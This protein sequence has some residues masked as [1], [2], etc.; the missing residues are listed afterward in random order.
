MRSTLLA[1][2]FLGSVLILGNTTGNADPSL[3]PR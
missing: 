3:E 2:A 1:M